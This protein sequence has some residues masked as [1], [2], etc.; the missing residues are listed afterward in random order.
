MKTSLLLLAA[1]A[2]AVPAIAAVTPNPLP[3]GVTATSPKQGIVDTSPNSEPYGLGL[4][5]VNFSFSMKPAVNTES[6]G[7]AYIYCDGSSVP[8]YTATIGN[9]SIDPQGAP[10]GEINFGTKIVNPGTYR[11]TIPEGFWLL[12]DERQLSPAIDLDY[13]ILD[14]CY[15]TPRQGVVDAV[16]TVTLTFP[17]ADEVIVNPDVTSWF[18]PVN[19]LDEYTVR[20]ELVEGSNPIQLTGTIYDSGGN[21]V[22]EFNAPGA[23]VFSATDGAF[24]IRTYGPDYPNNPADVT[25]V[26]SFE[27]RAQYQV[28]E[29]PAPAIVPA[30][31]EVQEFYSFTLDYPENFDLMFV[32]PMGYSCIYPLNSNGTLGVNPICT[33]KTNDNP[34]N[35][36]I[37]L[38][39]FDGES[40]KPADGKYVLQLAYGM[41]HGMYDGQ[42]VSTVSYEYEYEVK[43]STI[44]SIRPIDN[45]NINV[46]DLKGVRILNDADPTALKTLPAGL[47]I[48]NG[49][50]VIV[51]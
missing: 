21:R 46:F 29:V 50:K 39:P 45:G 41:M 18:L 3:A 38:T 20:Y 10:S 14:L 48:V 15:V 25:D 33:L 51:K 24:T 11:V 13:E 23:Y 8:A 44:V 42:F 27:I 47:Y 31:G 43:N 26:K 49:R 7:V 17:T 6:D 36:Q 5:C 2:I 28:T 30:P 37:V 9:V 4:I 34:E 22:E 19:T 1:M 35:R 16:S 32:D 40:V 12:G